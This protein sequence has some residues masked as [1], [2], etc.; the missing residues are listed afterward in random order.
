[1]KKLVVVLTI[2]SLLSVPVTAQDGLNPSSEQLD[3]AIQQMQKMGFDTSKLPSKDQLKEMLSGE[4]GRKL[5]EMANKMQ[6][7]NPEQFQQ[8]RDKMQ[9]RFDKNGDGTLGPREREMAQQMMKQ[10]R[11]NATNGQPSDRKT[12]SDK[13]FKRANGNGENGERST[14]VG[15]REAAHEKAGNH[16]GQTQRAGGNARPG[17]ARQEH[18]ARSSNN[19]QANR[20]GQAP[21]RGGTRSA[22]SRA[23]AGRGGR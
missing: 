2:L 23:A 8:M 13:A 1:M 20:G 3:Q 14:N 19:Q 18:S 6:Q 15:Q 21:N 12:T 9:N 11:A 10:R 16:Q 5:H 7:Q 4:N 17:Q 22:A